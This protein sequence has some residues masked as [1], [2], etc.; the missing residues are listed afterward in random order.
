[1]ANLTIEEFRNFF[2]YYADAEHQRR[3]VEE[4]YRHVSLAGLDHEAE[5]IKTYR[6][7]KVELPE[8]EPAPDPTPEPTPEPTPTAAPEWPITKEEMAEI[9]M[10]SPASLPDSLMDDF[11]KCAEL[12]GMNRKN[13]AYFLG[14]CGHESAGLRYPVEIHDGSN[15]EG[16][17]DLG[18]IY[19]GDG[20]K[21]AGTGW[22]QVTGRHNHQKF[23]DYLTKKGQ[24]DPKIMEIGKT[25]TSE[26][27]PWSCS[28]CWWELNGMNQYTNDDPGVDRV[29]SR[30]NGRYLPNGY[31]DR[32]DYSE[33]AFRV[34]GLPYPGN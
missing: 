28:G 24:F 18:N 11:A 30:V 10:C 33:R 3:A 32:R 22:I 19:P 2:K 26:K 1:M 15:Y 8:P 9:M 34:L 17:Q 29:G 13:I 12:Y 14:Q 25:Y 23:S 31:M 5:W 16:R 7:P 27:Y 4:L 20:V 6:S 21:F